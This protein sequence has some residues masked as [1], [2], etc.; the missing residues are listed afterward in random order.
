MKIID[1]G[2][3]YSDEEKIALFEQVSRRF[4]NMNDDLE[5]LSLEDYLDQ[6]EIPKAIVNFSSPENKDRNLLHVLAN[7]M[8]SSEVA[9]NAVARLIIFLA[10]NGAEV[11]AK[12][13]KGKTPLILAACNQFG[14]PLGRT[15]PMQALL[16][17]NANPNAA[18]NE[19]LTA[20][21]HALCLW[22]GRGADAMREASAKLL[23]SKGAEITS[24]IQRDF[25]E[26]LNT[27]RLLP[28]LPTVPELMLQ[29]QALKEQV[30]TLTARVKHLEEVG[31]SHEAGR[32]SGPSA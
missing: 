19:G 1:D 10:Q 29:I 21:H 5:E 16:N 8:Q 20:L 22:G 30:S 3:V 7:S 13:S 24:E 26:D 28:V 2:K 23:L 25:S 11:N 15:L 12:D 32:S 17:N 4:R 9:L 18:D 31:A 14:G 6:V 27:L